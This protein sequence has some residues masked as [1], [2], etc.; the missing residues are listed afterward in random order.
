MRPMTVRHAA[1]KPS[2]GALTDACGLDPSDRVLPRGAQTLGVKILAYAAAAIASVLVARALGPRERGA[3]SLAL[4][5]ASLLAQVADAGLSTSTLFLM[6]S[7]PD[8]VRAAVFMSTAIVCVSAVALGLLVLSFEGLGLARLLGIP[9]NLVAIVGLVAP[10][11]ALLGLIRQLLTA[12][13]DLPGANASVLGQ[14]LL[15]PVV[16]AA[17]LLTGPSVA[18]WALWGYL[19]VAGSALV[20]TGS[21]LL[22]RVPP[23]PLWDSRLLGTLLRL[24]VP[25]QLASFALTLT[26]RSDL[27]LVSHWL[28]LGAAGVYSIGLTLSEVLRGV[29]E[30]AQALVVSRTARPDLPSYTG[31]VARMTVLVT[32]GAGLSLAL[33]S[34]VVVPIVFGEAYRG[35]ALVLACLVPGVVGLAVSYAVSPLLFLEGRIV[36]S[37]IGALAALGVLWAASLYAPFEIGLPKVAVASSLAYWTLAGIQLAYLVSRGRIEPRAVVPGPNELASLIG[38]LS[39]RRR[40]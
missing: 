20:F 19:A 24:G 36:V 34:P 8:R 6:R 3:W 18:A 31:E 37:A 27:F 32:A 38:L 23:G 26:Y 13:G 10:V 39:R 25:S 33:V 16:L 15:L 22:R 30:T 11:L 9:F 2:G 29:P 21:R 28:G 35:A 17:M 12:L 7:R 14:S 1:E 5:L 4:L 40:G